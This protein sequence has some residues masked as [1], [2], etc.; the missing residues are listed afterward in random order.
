MSEGETNIMEQQ[1]IE[2]QQKKIYKPRK[3]K[4]KW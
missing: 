4:K 3:P 2:K 1:N